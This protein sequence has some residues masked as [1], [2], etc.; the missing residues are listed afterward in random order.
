MEGMHVPPELPIDESVET[1]SADIADAKCERE[2][3]ISTIKEQKTEQ[4]IRT[5]DILQSSISTPTSPEKPAT[6]QDVQVG[7]DVFRPSSSSSSLSSVITVIAVVVVAIFLSW[8]SS[9]ICTH[10]I[11]FSQVLIT[12]WVFYYISNVKT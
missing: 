8:I 10:K 5:F 2:T 4:S 9:P 1:H 6:L 12:F 3:K 7:I 11:Y